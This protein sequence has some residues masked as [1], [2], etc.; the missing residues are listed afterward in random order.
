MR[1]R[2]EGCDAAREVVVRHRER[3]PVAGGGDVGARARLEQVHLRHAYVTCLG[4]VADM[5]C[6]M[7]SS[8]STSGT[9]RPWYG[10]SPEPRAG[11]SEQADST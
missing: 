4:H 1:L 7:S 10:R 5:S 6:D 9:P 2:L 3:G 11:W 8:S